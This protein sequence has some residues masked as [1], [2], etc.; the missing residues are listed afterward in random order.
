LSSSITF[1]K[2]KCD[3]LLIVS[4]VKTSTELPTVLKDCT[5]FPGEI[6][7]IGISSANTPLY[8][9]LKTINI[10]NNFFSISKKFYATANFTLQN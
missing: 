1:A 2:E 5:V 8:G 9:K 4:L 3:E 7:T 6:T 10:F